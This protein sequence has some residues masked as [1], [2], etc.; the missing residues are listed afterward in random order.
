M[1]TT[2][3][4][5]VH[6]VLFLDGLFSADIVRTSSSP[7]PSK[8]DRAAPN[9]NLLPPPGYNGGSTVSGGSHRGSAIGPGS[10][11][12]QCSRL[13]DAEPPYSHVDD[14]SL[15]R[16]PVPITS[17]TD[18]V[19]HD[20]DDDSGTVSGSKSD[21][22]YNYAVGRTGSPDESSFVVVDGRRHVSITGAA[23]S[24]CS[25][26]LPNNVDSE[27]VAWGRFTSSGGRLELYDCGMYYVDCM[28]LSTVETR[29]K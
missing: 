15:R 26:P 12:S 18:D 22:G 2:Y 19:I 8:I 14:D 10:G 25:L 9:N 4:I 29:L 6:V 16:L 21:A 23:A 3:Q 11:S 20:E 24:Q 1:T 17:I 5:C 28:G 13:L 7:L 27:S